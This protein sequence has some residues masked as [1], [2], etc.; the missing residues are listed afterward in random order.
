VEP[1]RQ[2]L[3]DF[4][5]YWLT[6]IEPTVA[7]ST[8]YSYARNVKLHV[9]PHIGGTRLANADA[10]TL[11]GLYA[12]LLASGRRDRPGG[13]SP[14]SVAYVHTIL[15][16]ALK[17]AV[18]WG[19]LARNPAAAADPP[20]VRASAATEPQTWTADTLRD[21][22]ARSLAEGDRYYAGWHLLASTGMRRGEA[23]GLRWA[24]LD[25]DAS[26][27]SIRQTVI[28]VRHEVRLATPK[29]AKSRHR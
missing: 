16:R 23:L 15:G 9:I 21:F 8:H 7:A 10:G 5:G 2:S 19:R 20:R 17:D 3:A 6:T 28:A 18:R 12:Q 22:L 14:R 24:D 4:L 26:Y 1:G 13:L 11:N 29:T 25:L 27:A